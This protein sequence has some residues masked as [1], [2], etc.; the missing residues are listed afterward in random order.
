LIGG[1]AEPG[2]RPAIQHEARRYFG[3]IQLTVVSIQR[4]YTQFVSAFDPIHDGP[5]EIDQ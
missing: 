2:D 1:Y 4:E 3:K 5:L